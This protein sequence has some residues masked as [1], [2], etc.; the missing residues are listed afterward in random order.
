[1]SQAY[2]AKQ[3][4]LWIFVLLVI[5]VISYGAYYNSLV[6]KD[7]YIGSNYKN[8]LLNNTD[9][10]RLIIE[11][12]SNGQHEV[13]STMM[14]KELGITT[15]NL[16]DNVMIP[17]RHKLLRLEKHVKLGD[18]ILLPLG[19][20]HYSICPL[21][22]KY[23]HRIFKE[24]HMY[25]EYLT[26]VD[27]VKLMGS[28]SFL[29]LY[30]SSLEDHNYISQRKHE[31]SQFKKYD[32][33]FLAGD[34]GDFKI[35]PNITNTS[36]HLTCDEYTFSFQL[37]YGFEI[38]EIFKENMDIV[39]SLQKKG[40]K[41]LFTWQ[42]VAGDECYLSKYNRDA[43]IFYNKIQKYMKENE[44]PLIGN[45]FKNK[46][47]SEYIY[48]TYSHIRPKGRKIHTKNLIN[49]I[50]KSNYYSWFSPESISSDKLNTDYESIKYIVARTL[51]PLEEKSIIYF[52]KDKF[53]DSQVLLLEGWCQLEPWGVWSEGEMSKLIVK[54]SDTL[55]N[56]TI[57]MTL[58]SKIFFTKD[59]TEIFINGKLLGNFLLDGLTEITIPKSF[60]SIKK[61]I[62]EIEFENINIKSPIEA[63]GPKANDSRKIKLGIESLSFQALE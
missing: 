48:D 10:P 54:L 17:L 40:I 45:P 51:E 14:E 16:G 11:G 55:T 50:K 19:W 38:S 34:R 31:L 13:N 2:R 7:M 30:F 44:I 26:F 42:A 1:M 52:S 57:K 5:S 9:S 27:K 4:L 29:S 22:P 53:K 35:Q 41:F 15:I 46:F 59:K 12:G 24:H 43:H 28:T 32:S 18:I 6:P 62:L 3:F 8:F 21:S 63:M 23:A 39:K 36:K 33:R 58:L 20:A 49:T 60:I 37:R 56:K 47:S 25:Y 61:D